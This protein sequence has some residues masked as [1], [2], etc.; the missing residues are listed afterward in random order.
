M[1]LDTALDLFGEGVRL[2]YD[3]SNEPR[4]LRVGRLK[5]V[6]HLAGLGRALLNSRGPWMARP[7]PLV[8]VRDAC[9]MA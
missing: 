5:R 9:W 2:L 8:F 1:G 6:L 3:V 4:Q 7:L